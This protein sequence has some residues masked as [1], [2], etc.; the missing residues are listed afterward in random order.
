MNT[1][2]IPKKLAGKDDLVVIPKSEYKKL[3]K[4][5]KIVP[6]VQLTPSGK[7]S[8]NNGRKEIAQGKYVSL[9]QLENELAR[10]HRKKR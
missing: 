7:R 4:K 2:T 9:E 5:Q 8:L 3:L 6:I 10:T 1:I